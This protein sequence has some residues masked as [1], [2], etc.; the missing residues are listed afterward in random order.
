MTKTKH[1]PLVIVG[2]GPAGLT[3]AIYAVRSGIAVRLL[4][5][6]APGGQMFMIDRIENYPGF[7][8][9]LPAP[10]SPTVCAIRPCGSAP[11]SSR[12][13]SKASSRRTS[14]SGSFSE[15]AS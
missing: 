13:R 6:G 5:R 8:R 12:T 10:N 1:L 7:P 9:A 14:A 15:A 3:A 4:E 11:K 2:G